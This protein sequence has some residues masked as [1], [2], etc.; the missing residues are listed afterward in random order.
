MEN[1]PNRGTWLLAP[2]AQMTRKVQSAPFAVRTRVFGTRSTLLNRRRR[3]T[4]AVI[5]SVRSTHDIL[6]ELEEQNVADGWSCHSH[7]EAKLAE[8]ELNLHVDD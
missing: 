7:V 6:S 2:R 8:K 4:W 3:R 1:M 5:L